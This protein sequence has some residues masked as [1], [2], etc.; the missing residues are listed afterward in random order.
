MWRLARNAVHTARPFALRPHRD[1]AARR[2]LSSFPGGG[3]DAAPMNSNPDSSGDTTCVNVVDGDG[4]LFSATPSSGW[5]LGGAFIAGDTG[6]IGGN[7]SIAFSPGVLGSW[8]PDAYELVGSIVKF[9]K[10]PT[11]TNQ[12]YFDPTITGFTNF[13]GQ[14]YTN[15]FN[16]RAVK[17]TGT[18][19]PISPFAF[20]DS[21]SG[22]KQ[23]LIAR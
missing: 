6:T 17:V 9:T 10:N 21:G 12:M 1:G 2:A 13:T 23:L 15:T 7:N 8:R 11:F 5:V 16:F 3:H 22:T 4:N 20:I 14:S 18:N 19:L